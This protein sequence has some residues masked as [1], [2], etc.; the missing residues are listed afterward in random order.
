MTPRAFVY[1][2][3]QKIGALNRCSLNCYKWLSINRSVAHHGLALDCRGFGSRWVLLLSRGWSLCGFEPQPGSPAGICARPDA[4]IRISISGSDNSVA[5]GRAAR[6]PK[7]LCAKSVCAKSVCAKSVCASG[8][9]GICCGYVR[10]G[11]SGEPRRIHRLCQCSARRRQLQQIV[12]R[13]C[14]AEA[15]AAHCR[16]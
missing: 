8:Q 13:T 10:G 4:S 12:T 9:F 2:I 1:N 11:R 15:G 16:V 14:R 5:D 3:I 6:V 7:S